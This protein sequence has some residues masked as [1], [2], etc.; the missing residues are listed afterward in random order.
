MVVTHPLKAVPQGSIPH[1]LPIAFLAPDARS[2]QPQANQAPTTSTS[3][4][5]TSSGSSGDRTRFS[6]H[7]SGRLHSR[8][9][10]AQLSRGREREKPPQRR[11]HLSHLHPPT[12]GEDTNS[13]PC[14]RPRRACRALYRQPCPPPRTLNTHGF[15]F[16]EQRLATSL[17]AR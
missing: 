13:A 11:P 16:P 12:R 7:T 17:R 2:I 14:L 10:R 3:L 1:S 6:E 4:T 9:Q 8:P 15:Y 5:P